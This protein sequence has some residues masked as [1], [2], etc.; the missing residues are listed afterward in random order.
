M[1]DEAVVEEPHTFKEMCDIIV[2]ADFLRKK[3]GTAPTSEEIFNYN[4]TGELFMI[5]EWYEVAHKITMAQAELARLF[6]L[7]IDDPQESMRQAK[8]AVKNGAPT[9]E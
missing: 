1:V 9:R 7:A 2:A 4:S 8:E 3:D 5:F 6:K